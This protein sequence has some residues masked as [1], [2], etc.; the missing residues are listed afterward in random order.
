MLV[1]SAGVRRTAAGVVCNRG[2]QVQQVVAGGALPEGAHGRSRRRRLAHG[3]EG[4][5][6]EQL[7]R[8]RRPRQAVPL[9]CAAV[10]NQTVCPC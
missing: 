4:Q 2:A 6:L 7:L 5:G 3:T 9:R 8:Q 1:L 10:Q